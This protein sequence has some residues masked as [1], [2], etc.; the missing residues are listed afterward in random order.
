MRPTVFEFFRDDAV[1][2]RRRFQPVFGEIKPDVFADGERV[3][4]R[5]GLEHQRHAVFGG[6]FR[7][8]DGF[9]VDQNLPGVR[10]LQADEVLEQNAFAAAARP[11]DDKN[12]SGPDIKVNAVEHFLPAETFAQAA[13]LQADAGCCCRD[14]SS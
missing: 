7:R 5:A 9:A 10:R 14:R 11:H 2:F 4:Q 1:N 13:H 12:F 8:F 3:E 6:D